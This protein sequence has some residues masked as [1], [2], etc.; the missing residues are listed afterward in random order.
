MDEPAHVS[1]KTVSLRRALEES[2]RSRAQRRPR[3]LG[4]LQQCFRRI[5]RR[6]PEWAALPVR[7]I[8]AEDCRALILDTFSTPATQRKART[9]LHGVLEFS[10]RHGWCAQNPLE[11]VRLP[12]EPERPLKA[13]SPGQLRRLLD[14]ARLPEHR[15]AAPALGL[16]LWAGIRPTEL[17]HLRWD[18][19]HFAERVIAFTL[20]SGTPRRVPLSP[21]LARWL[22]ETSRFRL[23]QAPVV[24]SGWRRRW[25]ALRRAAEAA[26]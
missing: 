17:P 20:P 5:F 10:L 4:E 6:H 3:T 19:I 21:E 13:L 2:L 22:L 16:M 1:E 23:P 25:Q 11:D 8:C 7:A 18:D 15:P 14:T 9:L 12:S 26:P 24:P